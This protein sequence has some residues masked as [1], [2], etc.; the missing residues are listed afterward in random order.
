MLLAGADISNARKED[1]GK[2]L[3][4]ILRKI[5]DD[6]GCPNGLK[7]LGYT[8]EDIPALVAGTLPQVCLLSLLLGAEKWWWEVGGGISSS[9]K[10]FGLQ[11]PKRPPATVRTTV[12]RRCGPY[13]CESTY[14]CC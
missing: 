6:I 5:M 4:D 10:H 7:E 13:Q 11:R 14:G 1:A 9:S 2:I 3:S 12:L 8:T